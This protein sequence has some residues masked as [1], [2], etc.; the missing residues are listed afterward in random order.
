MMQMGNERMYSN[1]GQ[2]KTR[3][4]AKN[5]KPLLPASTTETIWKVVKCCNYLIKH[6]QHTKCTLNTA[7]CI[8]PILMP[9]HPHNLYEFN[10][11]NLRGRHSV[12]IRSNW[13]YSI[14]LLIQLMICADL[15]IFFLT[16]SPSW[17]DQAFV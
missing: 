1:N 4:I 9:F 13:K 6:K 12:W 16:D 11:Y 15:N 8:V 3:K 17:F 2:T 14:D 7:I 10:S 5:L